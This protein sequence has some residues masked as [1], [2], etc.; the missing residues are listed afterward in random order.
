MDMIIHPKWKHSKS[1]KE[2]A[3]QLAFKTDLTMFDHI[4]REEP[5]TAEILA[6]SIRVRLPFQAMPFNLALVLGVGR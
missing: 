3:Y 4:Y 1:P 6:H 5:E 2:T